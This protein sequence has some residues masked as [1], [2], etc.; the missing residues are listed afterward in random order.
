[1]GAREGREG[2]GVRRVGV[3]D[4]KREK[5]ECEGEVPAGEEAWGRM[6]R[7][8]VRGRVAEEGRQRRDGV[9]RRDAIK[10]G[11]AGRLARGGG[12]YEFRR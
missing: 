5:E 3:E 9:G 4:W 11:G 10:V 6:G 7:E 8:G 1:M 12:W 2:T